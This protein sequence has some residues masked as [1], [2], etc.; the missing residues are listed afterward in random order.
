VTLQSLKKNNNGENILKNPEKFKKKFTCLLY[1][2]CIL[3]TPTCL[4]G[5][6]GSPTC[7]HA[8]RAGVGMIPD[9]KKGAAY[10]GY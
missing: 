10:D 4:M 7:I 6:I 2:N 9:D 3:F 8:A 1:G 5:H